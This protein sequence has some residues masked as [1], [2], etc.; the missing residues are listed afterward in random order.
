MKRVHSLGGV[1]D[2][3]QVMLPG[4]LHQA[5]HVARNSAVV[6]R[7]DCFCARSDRSLDQLLIEVERVS[8]NINKDRMRS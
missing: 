6:N 4:D 8:T 2:Y 7:A 1:L 5:I 3:V